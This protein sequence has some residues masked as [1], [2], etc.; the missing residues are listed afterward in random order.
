M[1]MMGVY[2]NGLGSKASLQELTT[3]FGPDPPDY[4]GIA[5]A[6]GG[7]W[8]AKIGADEFGKI[9]E[10]LRAAIEVVKY[11]RRCAVVDCII[12]TN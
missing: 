5:S 12:E 2:P 1:S 9:A 7:A 6:A 3:G 11:E 8:G 4:A 10:T